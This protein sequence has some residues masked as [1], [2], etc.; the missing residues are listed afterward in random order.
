[1]RQALA[2]AWDRLARR[3][4]LRWVVAPYRDR[5]TPAGRALL[6][7]WLAAGLFGM[8]SL[9]APIYVVWCFATAALGAAEILS[10]AFLPVLATRRLPVANTSVGDEV[11]LDVAV[12]N[13]S[14]RTARDLTACELN[15]PPGLAV[16]RSSPTLAALA[17]DESASLRLT[18]RALKRGAYRLGGLR[19]GSAFPL[20]LWRE[21]RASRDI[22]SFLVY[23]RFVTP[24]SFPVPEG[25]NHQPGGFLLAS[26]VGES[27]E[28]MHTRE[29]RSGDNPRHVHWPST[30]RLGR[31]VVR[32]YHEEYFVRLAL[33][34]DTEVAAGSSDAGFEHAVSLAAG[35]ADYLSR[36]EYIIDLFAA[37]ARVYHFQSGRALAHFDHILEIL[38][39]LAA[40]PR[41]DFP[42]LT[43]AIAPEAPRLTGLVALFTD[44]SQER[45]RFV[46]ATQ[47]LGV[48]VRVVVVRDAALSWPRP[49]L[50][51]ESFVV[52]GT[53]DE[54]PWLAPAT[55]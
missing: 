12:R 49:A 53:G 15:L 21:L 7:L 29:Y 40:T 38:A 55:P 48:A 52:V 3:A 28:F 54:I 2:E 23:P 22:A 39:C 50:P 33:V 10:W 9:D 34:V 44:W 41:V 16:V 32:V 46:R 37:G 17:P 51:P 36:R 45:E 47:A 6:L 20:G 5:L 13:T 43:E 18:L 26:E 4:P 1:L 8:S 35:I 24:A 25:R 11:I 31:P 19:V 14:R 30:A 42:A 27:A